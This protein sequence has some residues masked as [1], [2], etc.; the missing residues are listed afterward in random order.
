MSEALPPPSGPAHD[1][2]PPEVATEDVWHRLDKKVMLLT[3]VR[4]LAGLALPIVLLLVGPASGSGIVAIIATAGAAVFAAA[5]GVWTWLATRYRITDQQLQVHTGLISRKVVTV[6]LNR[7]RS[8]DLESTIGHRLLGLSKVAVGTADE[9]GTAL[10]AL[11]RSDSEQLRVHLLRLSERARRSDTRGEGERSPAGGGAAVGDPD[12]L[13]GDPAAGDIGS[14]AG[15]ADEPT[16]E[17]EL[18]RINWGW[19]KFA[20]FSLS[21]LAIVAAVIGFGSQFLSNL[22]VDTDRFSM[23]WEWADDLS[24]S[25]LIAGGLVVVAIAWVVLSTVNYVVQ[26]WNLTLVRQSSGS[27]R[28]TRGLFTTR[29]TT[30]EES[31]IRGVE[32]IEPALLRMVK[33]AELRALTTVGA[34]KLLPPS[35][36]AVDQGIGSIVL[37]ESGPTTM[38]LR[39]HGPKARVRQ[40]VQSLI[41]MVIL[42][43]LLGVA[44]LVFDLA[45]WLLGLAAAVLLPLGVLLGW[46]SYRNLGHQLTPGHLIGRHGAL[47]RVRSVLERDGIIG[48]HIRQSFFQRRRGLATLVAT[49]GAS[50][51]HVDIHDVPWEVAVAVANASTPGVLAEF[52]EAEVDVEDKVRSGWLDLDL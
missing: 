5:A 38:P 9:A 12:E 25:V 27:L 47:H 33:G 35:P 16:W 24:I 1:L 48:W 45:W 37:E 32:L 30:V 18:T 34:H 28:L 29:S 39:S 15:A 19:L 26:W 2:P 10:D 8:V 41:S 22:E 40:Y 51:G 46:Q 3:P 42:L 4:I 11:A 36:L 17:V 14:E 50:P 7:I 6:R 13:G 43:A 49:T 31:R 23:L 20:P 21:S 52:I 44:I